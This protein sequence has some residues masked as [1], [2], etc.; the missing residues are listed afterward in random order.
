MTET[1]RAV[2]I[3]TFSYSDTSLILKAYTEKFGYASYLLKGYKK[4]K[5]NK[6]LLH[7]LN[8]IEIGAVHKSNTD[9]HIG[10]SVN[11]YR[12]V[13]NITLSPVKSSI[14]MFL[15][16]WLFHTV[17]IGEADQPF[18]NWLVQAIERLDK[19][20][21][22]GN[23][24]LWFLINLSKFMGFYPQGK[25]S[26]KTPLF[27]LTEGE[28]MDKSIPGDL[29]SEEESEWLDLILNS[30]YG[31]I[32]KIKLNRLNRH[33]IL[34]FFHHY[35]QICLNNDFRLKSFDILLQVFDD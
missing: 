2:V 28:F 15:A 32:D 14:A 31:S 9:L 17:R 20:D 34:S 5:K 7:P 21:Y 33:K 18:F 25:K 24:H 26:I 35:F 22:P 13:Q 11:S 30:N 6:I 8:L 29:L 1:T 3:H 27:N 23:F 19:S 16:E 10:R 12:S 4:R